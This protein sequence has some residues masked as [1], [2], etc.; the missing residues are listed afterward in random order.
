MEDSE[1]ILS[2]LELS[3][4]EEEKSSQRLEDNSKSDDIENMES[5]SEDFDIS[6]EDNIYLS[7]DGLKTLWYNTST[8][9]FEF[10]ERGNW[11]IDKNYQSP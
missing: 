2:S 6:V 11:I 7:T 4:L 3:N 5:T 1:D 10:N 9:R 8:S